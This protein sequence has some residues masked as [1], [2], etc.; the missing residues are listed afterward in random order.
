VS[1]VDF[2]ALA[3]LEAGLAR[4]QADMP[5]LVREQV[6]AVLDERDADAIGGVAA[7]AK[8][9]GKRRGAAEKM[10]SR[11]PELKALASF[12]VGGQR[13]WRRSEVL[14]LLASRKVG[15]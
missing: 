8:W 1:Q 2:G 11:D 10:I 14:A 13:R 3:R 5:R 9:T 7:V 15:K 4:L 12:T 6:A